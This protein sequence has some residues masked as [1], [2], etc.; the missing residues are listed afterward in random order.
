T[1]GALVAISPDNGAVIALA[2]GFDF[3]Y[4]KFNRAIQAARQPGSSFKP[5]LYLSGLEMGMTPATL[6]NDAPVVFADNQLDSSWRPQNSGGEFNGPTRLRQALYES[7]NLVSIR[8]LR[9]LGIQPVI[10]YVSRFG[11]SPNNMPRDLSLALGSAS[12]TPF[13]LATAY[14]ILANGGHRISPH[15]IQRI[16]NSAGETIYKAAPPTVCSEPCETSE[17]LDPAMADGNET[18][19][20][21]DEQVEESREIPQ[22]GMP[23]ITASAEPLPAAQQ[24]ADPRAVYIMHSMLRDVITKGTGRRALTLN[25]SDLA[26]KTGT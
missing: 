26:G 3:Y 24:I 11:F 8:L 15:F 17:Q 2:G 5:F 13:E 4:S 10:D 1:Q 20:G 16:D 19:D 22:S 12:L 7:R 25:R 23:A 6:I 9:S 18:V 21:S 14:A